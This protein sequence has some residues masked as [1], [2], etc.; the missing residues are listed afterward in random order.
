MHHIQRHILQVLCLQKKA[1]FS[2]MRPKNT[3]TNL[4]SYHL[5]L[6]IKKKLIEKDDNLKYRLSPKG[7]TYID[8]IRIKDFS[9][10]MKPKISTTTVSIKDGRVLLWKKHRQPFIDRWDL[11]NGKMYF[12]DN[13][14]LESEL[15]DLGHITSTKPKVLS[16]RGLI[17]IVVR[18]KGEMIAHTI[19]NVFVAEI[20]GNIKDGLQYFNLND[21]SNVDLVPGVKE[22]ISTIISEKEFFYKFFDIEW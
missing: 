14:I 22:I 18:I 1:R 11:P 16:H 12:E 17:E 20:D 7:L 10:K 2:E 19:T 13:N 8:Y 9:L 21:I 4:Y 3:D 5:K 15:R 6:L